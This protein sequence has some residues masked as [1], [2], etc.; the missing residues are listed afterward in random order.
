MVRRLDVKVRD[1][2]NVKAALEDGVLTGDQEVVSASSRAL[3]EGS[4]VRKKES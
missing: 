1:K 4:R 3:E 2:N